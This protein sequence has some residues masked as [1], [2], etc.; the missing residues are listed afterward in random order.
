[1]RK[2]KGP[3]KK[4]KIIFVLFF[5]CGTFPI[6]SLKYSVGFEPKQLLGGYEK[7]L[8]YVFFFLQERESMNMGS[9]FPVFDHLQPHSVRQS[10]SHQVHISASLILS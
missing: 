7:G 3:N 1:M 4:K 5:V 2:E 9:L 6:K 8:I 10:V